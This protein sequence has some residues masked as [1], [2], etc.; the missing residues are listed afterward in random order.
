MKPLRTATI[1]D[2]L[3]VANNIR[4]EDHKEVLGLGQTLG[5]LPWSILH[6]DDPVAFYDPEKPDELFGVAGV[7]PDPDNPNA[8]IVWMLCTPY[9]T[10]KPLLV[11]K[12]ARK[13]IAKVEAEVPVPLEPRRRQE[14]STSQIPEVIRLQSH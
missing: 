13:W 4:V 11:V 8:G 5:V 10:N 14:P 9:I 3:Y 2:A 7:V 6:S 1:K 12:E